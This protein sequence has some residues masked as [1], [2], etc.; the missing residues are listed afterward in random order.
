MRKKASLLNCWDH[1]LKAVKKRVSMDGEI[2]QGLAYRRA[3]GCFP[4]GVALVTAEAAEA[5]AWALTI[6][7]FV[8]VSLSPRLVMWSLSHDSDRYAVLA[9]APNWGVSILRADQENLSSRFAAHMAAPAEE[10]E[11]ERWVRGTGETAAPILRSAL[12][13]FDCRTV[14]RHHVGDHLLIVGEVLAFDSFSADALTYFRS[15]YGIAAAL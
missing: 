9:G 11:V 12:A 13:R 5:G 2:D 8:S 6:N 10:R 4:T 7:S 14:A 15:R 1:G 3:L